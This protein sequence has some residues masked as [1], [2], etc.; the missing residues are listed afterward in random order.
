[1][2]AVDHTNTYIEVGPSPRP[3]VK[4]QYLYLQRGGS[5]KALAR[6][7]DDESAAEFKTM[8]DEIFQGRRKVAFE[9]ADGTQDVYVPVPEH[10]V[11]QRAALQRAYDVRD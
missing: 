11:E 8:L 3:G 5:I 1:M 9:H 6:F 2:S 10:I 7:L 4:S